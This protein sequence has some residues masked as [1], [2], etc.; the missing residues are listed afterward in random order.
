[1]TDHDL[2]FYPKVVLGPFDLISVIF[3]LYFITQ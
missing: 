1:M 2:S 3:A